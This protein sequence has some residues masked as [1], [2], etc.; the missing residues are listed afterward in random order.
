MCELSWIDDFEL[1]QKD[2][3]AE[4][5]QL[6]NKKVI[7]VSEDEIIINKNYDKTNLKQ[8]QQYILDNIQNGKLN[9]IN[10][11]VLKEKVKQDALQD[12]LIKDKNDLKRR[13]IKQIIISIIVFGLAKIIEMLV[14][15]NLFLNLSGNIIMFFIAIAISMTTIFYPIIAIISFIVTTIKYK[16]DPYFRTE[17][18]K[19]LNREIEG[20]KVFLK[21]YT[22]LDEKDKEAVVVWEE[23]LVYSVLFNQNKKIV[24]QY[25][26]YMKQ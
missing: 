22:L 18:G 11:I 10:E 26:K 8:S 2:I 3:V 21:D 6:E 13:Q 15:R 7:T 1:E 24:E 25:K 16:M 23:Y 19:D 4:I 12:G 5:L 20:L 14:F 17:K 9:N